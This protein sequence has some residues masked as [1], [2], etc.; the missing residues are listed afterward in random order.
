M[1][2]LREE[3]ASDLVV[4]R[5]WRCH[6]C[7]IDQRNE[8]IERIR[9]FGAVLSSDHFGGFTIDIQNRGQLR[10]WQ[11]GANPSMIFPDTS[12]PHHSDSSQLAH[13]F[14]P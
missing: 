10:I 13:S 12:N 3:R 5:G 7:G 2:T 9:N 14:I 1:F 11:F 6:G 4:N 8:L